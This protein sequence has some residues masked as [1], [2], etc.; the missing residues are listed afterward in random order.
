MAGVVGNVKLL[1]DDMLEEQRS[2]DARGKSMRHG[3]A[4]DD[5]EKVLPLDRGQARGAA[6]AET[7]FESFQ[8]MLVPSTNP[9]VDTGAFDPEEMGNFRGGST[10]QAEADGLEAQDDAGGLVCLGLALPAQEILAC[11]FITASI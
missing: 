10:L 1:L 5:V 9:I 2:P 8:L 7:L 6:T 3:S 11:R 4:L